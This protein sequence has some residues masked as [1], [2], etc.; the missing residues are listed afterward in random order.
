MQSERMIDRLNS[1]LSEYI[2]QHQ[3]G[4]ESEGTHRKMQLNFDE[5]KKHGSLNII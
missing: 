1:K 3:L 4:L 5:L 2:R